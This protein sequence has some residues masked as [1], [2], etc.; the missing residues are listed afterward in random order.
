M[1]H[2]LSKETK[3]IS[4]AL[5]SL[6]SRLRWS[7]AWCLNLGSIGYLCRDTFGF[8]D[9]SMLI[10][11]YLRFTF[12][13]NL[14]ARTSLCFV[15]HLP[16]T[17]PRFSFYFRLEYWAPE[18]TPSRALYSALFDW[19]L[20]LKL[21]YLRIVYF[22]F[23]FLFMEGCSSS[24]IMTDKEVMQASYRTKDRFAV[25]NK[26]IILQLQVKLWSS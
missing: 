15:F 1:F 21:F 13:V 23:F 11:N 17:T 4:G 16:S 3:L 10:V 14:D 26:I 12:I 8:W 9:F 24:N 20:F 18:G 22:F 6:G 25:A 19:N 7:V 5:Q 2:K